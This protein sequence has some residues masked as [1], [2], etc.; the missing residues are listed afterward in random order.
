MNEYEDYII[1]ATCAPNEKG[2]PQVRAYAATTRMLT[3]AARAAHDT[4]PVV[5][6]ALGRLMTGAVMMG[7]MLKNDDDLLTIQVKGDGPVGG[8]VVTANSHGQVKGYAHNPSVVLPANTRHKLDVGG[9]VGHGTMSVIRDLGL[10]DPYVGTVDL[11]SGEI[12]EDLTWYFASSEQVPSA[13]ALGVLMN[14]ENTVRQAGGFIIQMMPFAEEETIARIEQNLSQLPQITNLLDSGMTPEEI[15][16]LAMEGMQ[17]KVTGK[18]PVEFHCDCS[19]KK[20][21]KV[22]L[23]LG[24]TE[25]QKLEEEG[26]DVELRC[27]FCNK[28]Y[29][30]TPQEIHEMI[31][32]GAVGMPVVKDKK[33]EE[34]V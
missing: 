25:L 17:V 23:S 29:N 24:R 1:S 11:Q 14:K 13:V 4:S 16:I 28:A 6:A 27:H 8:L 18:K 2:E 22:L 34:N 10:K 3:E 19:R 21:E 15:L 9:A 20:V 5:T 33:S 30:F 31:E 7:D 26:E 32:S 12:A